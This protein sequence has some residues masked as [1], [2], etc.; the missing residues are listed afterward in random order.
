MPENRVNTFWSGN[1]ELPG[2]TQKMI[3]RSLRKGMILKDYY[4]IKNGNVNFRQVHR[5]FEN[6]QVIFGLGQKA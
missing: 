5:I 2:V 4:L 1:L 3:K 6:L